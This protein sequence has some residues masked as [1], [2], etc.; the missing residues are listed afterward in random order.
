[1]QLDTGIQFVIEIDENMK[2]WV[3]C[4]AEAP[5]LKEH[6]AYKSMHNFAGLRI[7][8][9][10]AVKVAY[11]GRVGD[12]TKYRCPHCQATWWVEIDG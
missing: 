5:I 9:P 12:D 2:P 10:D 11:D 8:H 1:M 7:F 6:P 3:R 4:C